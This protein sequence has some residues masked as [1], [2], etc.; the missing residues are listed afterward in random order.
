M[1]QVE[2]D[3]ATVEER[4]QVRLHPELVHGVDPAMVQVLDL[5]SGVCSFDPYPVVLVGSPYS[6]GPMQGIEC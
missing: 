1:S 3:V 4:D 5:V 6:D 2:Q